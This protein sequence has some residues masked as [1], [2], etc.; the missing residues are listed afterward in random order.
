M[1]SFPCAKD[2]NSLL[3]LVNKLYELIKDVN[4]K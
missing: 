3:K 4:N 1:G 2:L